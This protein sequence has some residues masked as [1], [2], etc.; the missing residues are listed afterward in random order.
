[1]RYREGGGFGF[2]GGH[3][4]RTSRRRM[5]DGSA[6]ARCAKCW[7]SGQA[8]EVSTSGM[9]LKPSKDSAKWVAKI[10]QEGV[11]RC[12]SMFALRVPFWV[13]VFEPQPNSILIIL[14]YIYTFTQLLACV[15]VVSFCLGSVQA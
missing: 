13:S 1:M 8:Q 7:P 5:G 12:W 10:Q 3:K 6:P 15:L 2:W 14:L 9:T 4:R 11:R